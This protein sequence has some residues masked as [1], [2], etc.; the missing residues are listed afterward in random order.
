MRWLEGITDTTGII[1]TLDMSLSKLREKA[2]DR[3]AWSAVVHGVTMSQ[4]HL[5]E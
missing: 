1:D 5:S 3:G 4:T 2:K